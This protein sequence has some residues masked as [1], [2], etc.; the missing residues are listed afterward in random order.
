MLAC[1]NLLRK[2]VF[3]VEE[4]V[5]ILGILDGE[6]WLFYNEGDWVDEPKQAE[7]FGKEEAFSMC[8]QLQEESLEVVIFNTRIFELYGAI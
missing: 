2:D 5:F 1:C 6:S 4:T 3:Y 7:Q 8:E